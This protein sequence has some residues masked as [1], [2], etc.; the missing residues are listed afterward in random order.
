[1]GWI[2]NE[3]EREILSKFI[4]KRLL[5]LIPVLIILTLIVF[6]LMYITPGDP[7][8]MKLASQGATITP[9]LLELE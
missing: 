6:L 2:W 7:A 1:M 5:N 9:E 4:A 3:K 8:L